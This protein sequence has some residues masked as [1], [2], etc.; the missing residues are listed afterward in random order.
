MSYRYRTKGT[1]SVYI[2][3]DMDG[4]VV[5]DVTFTGGCHGNLQA[6]SRLVKGMTASEIK[7]KVDGIRC[8]YKATSC[9]DQMCR[10]IE[11]AMAENKAKAGC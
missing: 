6:I 9:A 1:C 8:G 10:A 2:D 4:D 11:L 3:V 7:E 5:R